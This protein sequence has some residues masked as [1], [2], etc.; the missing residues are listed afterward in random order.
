MSTSLV[1]R[2]C[3]HADRAIPPITAMGSASGSRV[4]QIC[5]S[6]R[7]TSSLGMIFPTPVEF[8]H[9]PQHYPVVLFHLLRIPTAIRRL[10]VAIGAYLTAES[11]QQELLAS[12]HQ[13]GPE[14]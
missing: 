12:I 6:V 1:A 10:H 13:V 3:F 2:T 11:G 8:F 5:A 4:R 14:R 9:H 7:S